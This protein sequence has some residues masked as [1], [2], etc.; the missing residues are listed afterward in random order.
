V[1]PPA[2]HG[3]MAVEPRLDAWLAE[4]DERDGTDILLTHNSAPLLRVDGRL[5]PLDGAEPLTGEEIEVIARNQIKDQYGDRLHVGRE[6]D[7]S[8]SWRNRA[9]IRA[10][11]FYQRG[12]CSLSLRR[13]P[14]KI[15]SPTEL[16]I[17][18]VMAGI[19]RN[20][21]GIIL[22]TGPTGSGK[23]TTMAAM[24][25]TINRS[26]PCHIVTIEDPIEYLHT[27]QVAAVSQ[28]E[29]G[30]DTESFDRALRSAL[31]ED[32][33]VVMVGEMR[34][35]ESIAFALTIAET[36]HLVMATM[37]TNDSAQTIDRIVDVFP[38]ERRPQIQVQL[39]GTLLAVIYQRLVPKVDAGMVAAYE[40]MV[41][42]PAVR[43][44]VREGKTR[45]LR[46]VVATHRADGMQTLEV[47]LD[48][49]IREGTIDYQT[50]VESSLYPQ[51]LT[52]PRLQ[53]QVNGTTAGRA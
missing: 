45:Q 10:N 1:T 41:G 7:F 5:T 4:L 6:V 36:G 35:L 21:S 33:D 53:P 12:N 17:P 37:H 48:A 18:G 51:D 52:K 23:S 14:M 30:T 25:D 2:D 49:L 16:G 34:D 11:A 32:P 13:I 28:R 3:Y 8:F 24:V 46:N 38:A 44:L 50:A 19:L 39:A 15:P 20:P 27:N 31:R 42:V 40:V 43:N 47:A 22:V 26:R 9:R 29:V